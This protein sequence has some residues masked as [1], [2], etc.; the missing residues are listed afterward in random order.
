MRRVLHLPVAAALPPTEDVLRALDLDRHGG[1][2]ARARRALDQALGFYA[3]RAEPRVVFESVSREELE[4]VL[5]EVGGPAG[6]VVGLLG[7]RARD[8]AL[9]VA[10]VGGTVSEHV[11]E[12]FRRDE[13][14]LAYLLDAVASVAADRLADVSAARFAQQL[15]SP[16]A[17]V[18]PYSPGYCG[19]PLSGQAA[20]FDRLRPAEI[21]VT[22]NDSFLM[23]PLKSVSGV[24]LAGPPE[25]HAFDADFDFCTDCTT[26][27]CRG[28]LGAGRLEEK[29]APWTS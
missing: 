21:G 17:L 1:L 18:L 6:S 25:I 12:L 15:S 4:D 23:T 10:T 19:W 5:L 9:F 29:Q 3:D 2:S 13:V 27:A 26:H 20:L 28:R 11:G 7:P 22:L 8:R 14:A 16:E 24:L